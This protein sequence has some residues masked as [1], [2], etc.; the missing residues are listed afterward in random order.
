MGD[1]DDVGYALLGVVLGLAAMWAKAD[2]HRI[3]GDYAW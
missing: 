3:L 2:A 1:L